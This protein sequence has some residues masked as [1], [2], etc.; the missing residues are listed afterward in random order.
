M[1][2]AQP[3]DTHYVVKRARRLL[4]IANANLSPRI[5]HKSVTYLFTILRETV[6]ESSL[7]LVYY[8]YAQSQTMFSIIIWGASPKLLKVFVAQK[9]VLRAM[10]GLRYWRRNCQNLTRVDH[11][12][13]NM[14]SS[15]FTRF[16]S[17]RMYEIFGQAS[18]QIQKEF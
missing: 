12:L 16:T 5:C 9:R 13:K 1:Q 10:A 8:A 11:C 15:L 17:S 2:P 14:I 4:F 18:R 3:Y 6:S 7:K